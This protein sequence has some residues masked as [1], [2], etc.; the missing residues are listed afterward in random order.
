MN[1]SQYNLLFSFIWNIATDVLVHAQHVQL[2][3]IQLLCHYIPLYE[4]LSAAKI[5]NSFDSS[6]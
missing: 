6:K 5:C 3:G 1:Q 2:C 4:T